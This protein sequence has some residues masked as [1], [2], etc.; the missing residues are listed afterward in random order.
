[1]NK[2]VYVC[3]R[4]GF[5]LPSV[6]QPGVYITLSHTAPLYAGTGLTLTCTVTLDSYVD[7]GERVMTEW[8]GLQ[9]I[10]EERYSV[11][12]AS[13]PGSTYT[14]S[15]TFSPL[16]DQD[17]GTYTCTVVVTGGNNVQQATASENIIVTGKCTTFCVSAPFLFICHPFSSPATSRSHDLSRRFKS[18]CWRLIHSAVYSDR[19][20][21][22]SCVT[23]CGADRTRRHCASYQDELDSDTHFGPSDDITCWPVHLQGLSDDCHSQ[24]GYQWAEYLYPHCAE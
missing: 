21:I 16:A 14:S 8:S 1:M 17:D 11:I 19:Y 10:P 20:P 6:P 24:C 22:P 18:H 15:L 4:L 3:V 5:T 2:Y 7:N 13:G 9:G 23:Y 12:N